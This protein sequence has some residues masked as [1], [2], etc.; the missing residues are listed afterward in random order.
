MAFDLATP[1]TERAQIVASNDFAAVLSTR[2]TDDD[3]RRVAVALGG[4]H[5]FVAG[6]SG[7]KQQRRKKRQEKMRQAIRELWRVECRRLP[8]SEAPAPP[9]VSLGCVT[10]VAPP[11]DASPARASKHPPKRPAPSSP[12]QPPSSQ[13][14][15]K[16]CV[17]ARVV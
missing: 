13:I 6:S 1:P 9:R 12:T 16:V 11:F 7:E 8:P 3:Y 15:R 5:L 4:S 2:S 17:S 14:A 10:N